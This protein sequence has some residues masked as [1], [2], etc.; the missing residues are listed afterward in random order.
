MTHFRTISKT[1]T[2]STATNQNYAQENTFGIC[3]SHCPP[4]DETTVFISSRGGQPMPLTPACRNMRSYFCGSSELGVEGRGSQKQACIRP[5]SRK[6]LG[7]RTTSLWYS[8]SI[9]AGRRWYISCDVISN[10]RD[11][12]RGG[13]VFIPLSSCMHYLTRG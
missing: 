12:R 4:A 11:K 9:S 5:L 13:T 2:L 7:S 8:L 6:D 3:G 1:N 10:L